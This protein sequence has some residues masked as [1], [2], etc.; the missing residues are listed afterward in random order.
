MAMEV[1]SEEMLVL[2]LNRIIGQVH[3]I[4]KMMENHRDCEDIITQLA[5]VRSA[6]DGVGALMIKDCMK[7]LTNN[8]PIAKCADIESLSR[9][10][11]IW[12]K[13]RVGDSS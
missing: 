11:A 10:I 9:A 13:L 7:I 5:A 2:R 8:E 6:I 3:G 4:Q 12:S 1:I